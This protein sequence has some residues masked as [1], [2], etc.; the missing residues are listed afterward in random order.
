M[1]Q[2]SGDDAMFYHMTNGK[3][4]G[5]CA[6]HVDDFLTGGTL[7]FEKLLDRKLQGGFKFGKI[8]LQKFKFTGL[9]IK[10]DRDSIYRDQIDYIQSLAPIQT[11]RVADKNE[12]LSPSEF[13]DYRALT[14]QLSWAAENSRPDLSYD[15]R[16]LATRNKF[17][18]FHD[19][20]RANKVLR[21][22]QQMDVKIK[23]SSLGKLENLKV[24]GFTDSS[25]RNA[26]DTSKSVGGRLVLLM[27]DSGDCSPLAWKSKTIQQV[28]KSVKSAETRSL[29]LGMEDCIFL[30]NMIQEI[31]FGKSNQSRLPVEMKID[32][33]TLYD[34]I[35]SSKQVEEKTIRHIIAWMK[36]QLEEKTVNDISWVSS[37]NMLA[38]IFTKR[39]VNSD[40]LVDVM[41]KG[42]IP[43]L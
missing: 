35:H 8:E 6:L 17:A 15:V 39:N 25:Y 33:K 40:S 20:H 1:L 11:P 32:S 27:N 14:G 24:I 10:P 41:T 36:Q 2:L 9:N 12:K 21:K 7:E 19:I 4:S 16:E 18:T 42:M 43:K 34:S 23:F 3:L 30:C 22:A 5:L 26:E 13:K 29:D 28:C 31:Y 37:S 38:D